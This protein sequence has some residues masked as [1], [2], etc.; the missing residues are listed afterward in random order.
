MNLENQAKKTESS[1]SLH[2]HAIEQ[3]VAILEKSGLTEIDYSHGDVSIRVVRAVTVTQEAS[4]HHPIGGAS[5]S[6][7]PALQASPSTP[8]HKGESVVS[9]MVGTVYLTPK[10]GAEPFIKRGDR[11]Q[12]GQVLLI[13]EA[14]KVMNPIKAPK[15]GTISF[16]KV[17]SGVPVEYGEELLWID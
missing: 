10:P 15:A 6:Q 4:A 8:Q 12:E 16:I 11:V 2:T 9:P 5:P 14:M 3:L 7:A 1:F 13:I 17:A